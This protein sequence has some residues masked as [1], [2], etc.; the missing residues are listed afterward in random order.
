MKLI[1]LNKSLTKDQKKILFDIIRN[2]IMKTILKVGMNRDRYIYNDKNEIIGNFWSGGQG[3]YFFNNYQDF[4]VNYN[5]DCIA[6]RIRHVAIIPG[7]LGE[8]KDI[9]NSTRFGTYR[10]QIY[11]EEKK[12]KTSFIGNM[13]S[14]PKD[15]SDYLLKGG[16]DFYKPIPKLK[17]IEIIPDFSSILVKADT[18]IKK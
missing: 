17:P 11:L 6:I 13:Y 3:N 1:N 4:D 5:D 10:T 18:C 15:I 8:D 12:S 14:I 16:R 9:E 2:T 7:W